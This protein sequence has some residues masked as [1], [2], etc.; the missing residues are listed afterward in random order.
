[1]CCYIQNLLAPLQALFVKYTHP[2]IMLGLPCMLEL[3]VQVKSAKSQTGTLKVTH[4]RISLHFHASKAGNLYT[5]N[6]SWG[7]RTDDRGHLIWSDKDFKQKYIFTSAVEISACLS[8]SYSETNKQWGG[9]LIKCGGEVV[10][11]VMW[12]KDAVFFSCSNFCVI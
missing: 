8:N 3:T 1:M 11:L 4:F 6:S 7:L 10:L 2:P 9:I 5:R 12:L